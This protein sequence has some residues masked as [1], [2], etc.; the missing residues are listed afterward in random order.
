[1]LPPFVPRMQVIDQPVPAASVGGSA[2]V[3]TH[4][5]LKGGKRVKKEGKGEGGS[6]KFKKRK[7]KG[8]SHEKERR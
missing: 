2:T 8:K 3:E 5:S 1:M 4:R 6:P 7:G